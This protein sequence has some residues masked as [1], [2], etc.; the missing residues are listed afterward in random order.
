MANDLLDF[1]PEEL[2]SFPATRKTLVMRAKGGDSDAVNELA[3]LYRTPLLA[4]LRR[5]GRPAD[6]A[7]D[8]VQETLHRILLTP[9]VLERLDFAKGRFRNLVLAVAKNVLRE[10]SRKD[11]R[12]R[13]IDTRR[14]LEWAHVEDLDAAFHLERARAIAIEAADILRSRHPAEYFVYRLRAEGRSY[15]EIGMIYENEHRDEPRRGAIGR[16]F[17]DNRHRRAREVLRRA[18]L[19]RIWQECA[20]VEEVGA[21][22]QLLKPYLAQV[23][24]FPRAD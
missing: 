6:Q 14:L 10:H 20:S 11:S 24:P 21:E 22:L 12:E 1:R 5:Q 9:R 4:Y 17:I 2:T 23:W 18:I 3:G 15:E 7:E 13:D 16:E 19:D 8:A